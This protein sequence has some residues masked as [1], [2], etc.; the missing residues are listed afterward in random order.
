[1]A[2]LFNSIACFFGVHID[3]MMEEA[4]GNLGSYLVEVCPHCGDTFATM[5][6]R[7]TIARKDR[8]NG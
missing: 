8:I 4:H 6:Y 1:M 5:I 3:V 2:N 7:N